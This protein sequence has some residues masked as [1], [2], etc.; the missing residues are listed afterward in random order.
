ML[1]LAGKRARAK[2]N[3]AEL[4]YRVEGAGEPLLLLSPLGADASFWLRQLPALAAT[5][6]V[7]SF[8]HRGA[9]SSSPTDETCSIEQMADDAVALLDQLGIA[10]ADL[11]GLAIGSLVAQQMARLA[12]SRVRSLVLAA[13]YMQA[14]PALADIIEDWRR[15]AR[16]QGMEALFDLCLEWLF[17]TDYLAQ[18]SDEV[19]K[20]RA[21]Y[22]LMH[23]DVESFCGQSLAGLRHDSRGWVGELGHRALILHGAEDRL[24]RLDHAKAL[25]EAM[26]AAQLAVIK[27]APHFLNW[28]CAEA[29]NRAIGD[30]LG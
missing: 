28:E 24:V 20:L 30:F 22:R 9:P 14:D 12:P 29:F 23:Q 5:R 27:G 21:V 19:S 1:Y 17:T 8:G 3:G 7:I 16:R 18:S 25:C 26:P 2:L 6:Q 13:S 11:V 4:A 10:S 15:S